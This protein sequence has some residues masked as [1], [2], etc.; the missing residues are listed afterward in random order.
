MADCSFDSS[1]RSKWRLRRNGLTTRRRP[2]GILTDRDDA[3]T[4]LGYWIDGRFVESGEIQHRKSNVDATAKRGLP[5]FH[6]VRK[7]LRRAEKLLRN[8]SVV[9]EIQSAIAI[10]RKH[11]AAT[12]S[13]LEQFRRPAGRRHD[14]ERRRTNATLQ[15]IRARHDS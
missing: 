2:F 6:P 14:D 4:A 10:I 8:M 1:S 11:R 13:G 12:A 3:E 5:L 9:S 7:N 15:S